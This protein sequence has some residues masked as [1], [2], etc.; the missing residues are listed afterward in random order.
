[1][2]YNCVSALLCA[3]SLTAVGSLRAEVL[4]GPITNPNNGHSY[5]L[6]APT[7]WSVA[8]NEAE[9]LGGT[10]A[11]IRNAAE[12]EWVYSQFAI[13][14]GTNRSL[15]IGLRRQYS[16]GPFSWITEEK[17]NYVNWAVGQPDNGGGREDCVHMW[18]DN[19]LGGAWNDAVENTTLY[20]VVEVPGLADQKPLG[21][22][23]KSLIGDWYEG[24]NPNRS[25]WIVGTDNKLF[26]ITHDRHASRLTFTP[27]GFIFDADRVMGELVSEKIVWSNGTWWSKRPAG[28]RIG[29]T[30]ES[31]TPSPSATK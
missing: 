6:L 13:D 14:H 31:A 15:W 2:K 21:T 27:E 24:G 26:L 1:M 19:H 23:E 28:Y 4:A 3:L 16:G 22:R 8:E 10:L 9:G 5:Y 30:A 17:V 7:S 11:I 25:A 20:G 29:G 12:Q 18:T